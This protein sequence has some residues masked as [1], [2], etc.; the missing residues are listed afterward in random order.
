MSDEPVR[1]D[2]TRRRVL[3]TAAG[4]SVLGVTGAATT[5]AA[6]DGETVTLIYDT[7]F[8][9]QF[10]DEDE[11]N[12]AR[13]A[14]EVQRLL[15]E[16]DNA[17]FVGGG[18][19]LSPSVLS[20]IYEGEHMVPALNEL[21]PVVNGVSHHDYDFGAEIAEERFE[22]SEFPWVNAQLL[23]DEGEPAPGIERWVTVDA[24]DLTVGFFSL[25]REDFIPTTDYPEE[26]QVLDQAEAAEE[27]VA[28]LEEEG[29]DV[30]VC[31]G[32]VPQGEKFEVP[33]QV[34]GV[35]AFIGSSGDVDGVDDLPEDV[36]DETPEPPTVIDGSIVSRVGKEFDY[37]GAL[38][39]DAG[40]EFVDYELVEVD[41]DVEPDS[42]MQ[43]I[44]DEWF[45]ELREEYDRPFFT[46][47]E[48]LDVTLDASNGTESVFGNLAT[49]AM[50][51]E[52]DADLA[53]LNP[54]G[55]RTNDVY[56]PG[57]IR[58]LDILNILPFPN[59]LVVAEVSGEAIVEYL[60]AQVSALPESF[61]GAQPGK[62]VAG[63][64]YE[65]SGHDGD[66]VAENFYIGDEPLDPEET[67]ELATLDFL[68]GARD[69][70]SDAEV[71]YESEDFVGPIVLNALEEQGEVSTRTDERMLRVDEDLGT[72]VR[73][74]RNRGAL[75]LVFNA[76]ESALELQPETFV[77]V[78]QAGVVAEAADAA[79]D[80]EADELHVEFDRTDTGTIT[81]AA[82][83]PHTD[84][85][86]FGGYEPDEEFFG[87]DRE[88]PVNPLVESYR[89]KGTVDDL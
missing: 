67:Y 64:Q 73:R 68:L 2:A 35:D 89:L 21:D 38:T 12:I 44:V 1:T 25:A 81:S 14:T 7:H 83:R 45:G 4:V 58:G 87:Y 70:L 16:Y 22:D 39:L 19:D 17:M 28:A 86:I 42:S 85:R 3:Q 59:R 56:G 31:A 80:E 30:I 65:W 10:G 43:E 23:T 32:R 40:G 63:V 47:D 66:A 9:G 78:T 41:T 55:I 20:L 77:A 36:E 72:L 50:L 48:P 27:A 37:L 60:S 26:W 8:D 76:P 52:G 18:D 74:E 75:T 54:G 49:E 53:I 34:D 15:D 51:E 46:I 29:A 82:N 24:G 88:L 33:T 57:E 5:G 62:Q 69:V 11:P 71:V 13:Y 84:L 79:V 6:D 61:F